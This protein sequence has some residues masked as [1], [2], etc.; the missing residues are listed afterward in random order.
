MTATRSPPANPGRMAVF[1]GPMLR[2]RGAYVTEPRGFGGVSVAL[3]H[4]PLNLKYPLKSK[5]LHRPGRS[6][7]PA[8]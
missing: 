1:G 7:G 8:G 3:Y 4:G 2:R 6:V 5:G